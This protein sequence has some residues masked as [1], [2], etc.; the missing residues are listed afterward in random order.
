MNQNSCF[1]HISKLCNSKRKTKEDSCVSK[2]NN[3]LYVTYCENDS[4]DK[5]EADINLLAG[6]SSF[7]YFLK[8]RFVSIFIS[9]IS[10]LVILIALLSVSIYEDFLKKVIFEMPFDW[11][12]NDYIAFIYIFFFLFL[13]L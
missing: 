4:L 7:L 6:N 2:K 8:K 11:Q 9:V 10:V 1:I 13:I 3:S 12:L 5:F